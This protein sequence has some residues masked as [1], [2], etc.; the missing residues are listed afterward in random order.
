M[1]DAMNFMSHFA[2]E[3][4]INGLCRWHYAVLTM[5]RY[6]AVQPGRAR[7]CHLVGRS[8]D[9]ISVIVKFN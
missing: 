8:A 6:A 3:K 7:E 5:L 2:I 1:E 4:Y 9:S